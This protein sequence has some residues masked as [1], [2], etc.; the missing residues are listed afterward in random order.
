M[1]R[2]QQRLLSTS[3]E[4]IRHAL[5]TAKSRASMSSFTTQSKSPSRVSAERIVKLADALRRSL[6]D[7]T[8]LLLAADVRRAG[9]GWRAGVQALLRLVGIGRRSFLAAA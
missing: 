1:L 6:S 4:S 5:P 3:W 2:A 9:V 8:G 7:M